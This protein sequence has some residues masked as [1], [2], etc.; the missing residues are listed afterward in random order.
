MQEIQTINELTKAWE[1]VPRSGIPNN[2]P[3]ATLL[4][5]NNTETVKLYQTL[6]QVNSK[7]TEENK[8][9]EEQKGGH[10]YLFFSSSES[11]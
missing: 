7:S 6:T 4:S 8:E 3:A 9:N 5:I 11:I 1:C 10:L 2:F